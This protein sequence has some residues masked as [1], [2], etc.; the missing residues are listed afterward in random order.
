[1]GGL[2]AVAIDHQQ[3]RHLD[4]PRGDQRPAELYKDPAP[5]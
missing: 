3:L 1:V 4:L 5:D 2:G